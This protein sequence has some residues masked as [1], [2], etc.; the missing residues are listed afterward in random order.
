MIQKALLTINGLQ[1]HDMSL[2]HQLV[3]TG[4]D[5]KSSA[6]NYWCVVGFFRKY[7]YTVLCE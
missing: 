7:I 1:A 2:L 4:A 3:T 5:Y 6:I